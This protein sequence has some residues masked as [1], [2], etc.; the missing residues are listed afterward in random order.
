M[1]RVFLCLLGILIISIIRAFINDLLGIHA[2][3]GSNLFWYDI[4]SQITGGIMAFMVIKK[5]WQ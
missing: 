4:I 3:M 2:E 1:K 5:S